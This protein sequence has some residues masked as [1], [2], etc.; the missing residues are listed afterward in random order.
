M[1]RLL[2]CLLLVPVASEAGAQDHDRD[3]TWRTYASE[4]TARVRVYPSPD[5]RRPRAVVIDD[6]AS[7]AGVVTEEAPYVAD[8]IGREFGFDPVE[9]TYVFRFTPASFTE[10]APEAGKTLL[11]RAT[12]RRTSSGALGAPQWR[13]VTADDVDDLTDRAFR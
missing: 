11:L 9:A 10:G 13:V 3:V 7:N 6:Q 12:F 4:R 2:V 8:L 5:E 1:L